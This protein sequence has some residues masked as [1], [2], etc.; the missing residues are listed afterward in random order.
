MIFNRVK[1][2][3]V[4]SLP[5]YPL[6]YASVNRFNNCLAFSTLKDKAERYLCSAV[7]YHTL[8]DVNIEEPYSLPQ[9]KP[10]NDSQENLSK[11]TQKL[12]YEPFS[13]RERVIHNLNMLKLSSEKN[14]EEVRKIFEIG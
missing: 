13:L 10:N 7:T 5:N 2:A 11:E 4:A 1:T 14:R 6:A 9:L 12:S 3:L 8:K